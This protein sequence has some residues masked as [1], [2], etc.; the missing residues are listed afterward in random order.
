MF[1]ARLVNPVHLDPALLIELPQSSQ[2]WLMDCGDLH[3]L[4]L[5]TLQSVTTVFLS[6]GHIDHW[7]GLDALVRA[8]LFSAQTLRIVGPE[9]LLQLL[10]S[11]LQG[12]AWNLIA[13]S[14]FVV[15]GYQWQDGAWQGRSFPCAQAFQ[16]AE[17][18]H[19]LPDLSGWE[20][21]WV[22]VEHGVPCLGYRLQHPPQFRFSSNDCPH[23]PGPWVEQSKQ[24]RRLAQPDLVIQI[25]S[26]TVR[27]EQTWNWLEPLP[28][29]SLAY[30]TDT[31][32]DPA[33]RKRIAQALGPTRTLW[34]EAA[35]LEHQGHLA[36]TKL[37]ATAQE[38][39][40]LAEE[41]PCQELRLFHL[42]RR[43]QGKVE[44]HLNEARQIFGP[45]F[46][47]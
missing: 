28:E 32:L 14:P 3:A 2:K 27:A 31:R 16:P 8:Q 10:Q 20:L 4:P 18:L 22:E 26:L 44:E 38:A 1:Q 47:G 5:G 23:R 11:R 45:T 35:F 9:G 7:I 36:E 15:E 33:T 13:D 34:C 19:G 24:S 43:T 41:L 21:R 29:M 12:Y 40:R 25:G 6:H 30:I 39:A 46:A 42:S 37:H 17:E